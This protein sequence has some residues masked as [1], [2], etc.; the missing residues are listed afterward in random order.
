MKTREYSAALSRRGFIGTSAALAGA[1]GAAFVGAAPAAAA[2]SKTVAAS[3]GHKVI[4]TD[5]G[6]VNHL[7]DNV[8]I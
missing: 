5:S 8:T 2:E 7:T 3:A 4:A 1:S 6:L